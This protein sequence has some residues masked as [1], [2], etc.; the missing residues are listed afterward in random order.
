[1]WLPLQIDLSRGPHRYLRET[2]E[3]LVV[4]FVIG[5]V[6]VGGGL[7]EGYGP[8][9]NMFGPAAVER[10]PTLGVFLA[11]VFT[12]GFLLEA[13]LLALNGVFFKCFPRLGV[14]KQV[15]DGSRDPTWQAVASK[16]LDPHLAPADDAAWEGAY[17]L[18]AAWHWQQQRWGIL[19]WVM[20]Q[21]VGAALLILSTG[22][23][24]DHVLRW[25]GG[26]FILLGLMWLKM[27]P[28][29]PSKSILAASLLIDLQKRN[30]ST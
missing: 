3:D 11:L 22:A 2:F 27:L 23:P 10:F 13:A 21:A 12:S 18:L 24:A 26:L 8:V 7:A 30:S 25:P 16:F 5:F 4:V 19:Q 28:L 15:E 20:L 29:L 14:R 6:F 9:A 1:M 17:L